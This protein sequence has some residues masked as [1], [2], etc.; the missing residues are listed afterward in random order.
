MLVNRAALDRR[1]RPQLGQRRLEARGAVDDDELRR[2][3]ATGVE[4]VEER[5][6]RR[7]AL[8]AHV[9]DR[10]QDLLPVPAHADRREHRDRRRL[11]VDPRLHHRAVEDQ[12][13]DVLVGEAA[14]A[15][16]LPVG[17]DLAPGPAHHV[18]AHRPF[19]QAEQRALH[20]PRVGP[21]EVDRGDQRLRL[22]RQPL[23][24]A[25]R[26]RPPFRGPAGLVDQPRPRHLHRL[27]AERADDLPLAVAVAMAG[28]ALG[29]AFVSAAA[30]RRLQLLLEDRLDET[31][32]PLPD[33][34][35]QRVK[36]AIAGQ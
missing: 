5:S 3:Q 30:Q 10:Q 11:P 16:R 24:A 34:V 31:A 19:E 17:L 4:I 21:G 13:D 25:Q 15:P 9:P 2:L 29:R 32:H 35:F 28:R 26:L 36:R 6:P 27:G 1:I 23:I 8:A 33:P 12:P 20:P 18:L 7:L 14:R 22:L